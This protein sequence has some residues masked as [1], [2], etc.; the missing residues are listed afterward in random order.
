MQHQKVIEQLGYSQSEAKVYMA[1]LRLGESLVSN[2]AQKVGMPRNTVQ[3]I[4]EKLHTDGLMSFY[5]LRRYKYWS[6][7]NPERLLTNLQ[8][9]EETVKT[10]LPAL[11]EM[12]KL[13]RKKVST[14]NP[15]QGLTIIKAWADSSKQ[16]M[17]VTDTD[18]MIV[19]VNTLWEKQFGYSLEEVRGK[20]TKHLAS[21]KTPKQIHQAMWQA[22]HTGKLFQTDQVIDKRKDGTCFSMQTTVFTVSH[23]DGDYFVQLL[24]S[25]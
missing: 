23:G 16:P 2:I 17:L 13:A 5:V 14:K 6:V 24:Q 25:T 21:G 18:A 4:V 10:A 11:V 19:Y 7:E 22:L 8:K 3:A 12:R 15:K 20:S 9:R 1:A